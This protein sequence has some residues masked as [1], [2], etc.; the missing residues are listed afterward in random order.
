MKALYNKFL[1]FVK[2][3]EQ[4]DEEYYEAEKEFYQHIA[5]NDKVRK[6]YEGIIE[7]R[8]GYTIVLL[9]SG[10]LLLILS[11]ITKHNYNLGI[12]FGISLIFT[13]IIVMAI[14]FDEYIRIH[15]YEKIFK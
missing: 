14:L 13:G 9:L 11:I 8:A 7:Y 5:Q 10:L 6:T 1:S 4:S 2:Q 12:I 15:E 3:Y